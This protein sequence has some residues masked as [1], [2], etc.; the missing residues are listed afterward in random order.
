MPPSD[1]ADTRP[2]APSLSAGAEAADTR[3]PPKPPVGA[4]DVEATR[5]GRANKAT[6]DRRIDAALLP[7]LC[8]VSVS[9]Y[10]GERMEKQGGGGGGF[11]P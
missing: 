5:A 7:C 10:L 1:D 4:L 8:A 3:P 11:W 2:L 9:N 6:L